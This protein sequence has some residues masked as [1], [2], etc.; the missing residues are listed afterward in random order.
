MKY[1]NNYK[2]FESLSAIQ[3]SDIRDDVEGILID[4]IDKGCY[5]DVYPG[6]VDLKQSNQPPYYINNFS[7]D[8]E[9]DGIYI[10]VGGVTHFKSIDIEEY[11]LTVLDYLKIKYTRDFSTTFYVYNQS[12]W[13][14]HTDY[15]SIDYSFYKFIISV[16]KE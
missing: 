10:K 5:V 12:R 9:G 4:L 2:M 14:T 3:F 6:A 8:E 1:I 15:S 11:I 13:N 7:I 16:K